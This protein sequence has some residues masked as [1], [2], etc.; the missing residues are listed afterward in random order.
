VAICARV[1]FGG[2]KREAV[3]GKSNGNGNGKK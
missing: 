2:Q 1:I 3:K